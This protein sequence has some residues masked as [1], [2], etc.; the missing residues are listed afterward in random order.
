LHYIGLI[1]A[2]RLKGQE[3]DCLDGPFEIDLYVM[4]E[5]GFQY[6]ILKLWK[7]FSED[8]KRNCPA[9]T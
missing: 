9:A 8:M 3:H 2:D 5:F 1:G 6:F 7:A 4:K